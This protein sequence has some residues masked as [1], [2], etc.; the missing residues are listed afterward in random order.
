MIGRLRPKLRPSN[1]AGSDGALLWL[2]A[3]SPTWEWSS[4]AAP[5]KI[6]V[7]CSGQAV[8]FRHSGRS[9]SWLESFAVSYPASMLA[10]APPRTSS[11][12]PRVSPGVP[13]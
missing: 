8:T 12:G 11:S 10:A 7:A 4:A 6:R 2:R 5:I 3:L 1:T 13:V 9:N